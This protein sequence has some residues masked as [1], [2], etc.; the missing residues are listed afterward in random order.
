MITSIDNIESELEPE[1]IKARKAIFNSRQAVIGVTTKEAEFIYK[2]GMVG[3][4]KGRPT[5]QG[6]TLYISD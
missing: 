2:A 5:Y 1:V 3:G 4:A 6:I